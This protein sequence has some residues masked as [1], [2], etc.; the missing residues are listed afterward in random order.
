M[1]K[2]SSMLDSVAGHLE[3]NGLIKEAY[4]IDKVADQIDRSSGREQTLDDFL[5]GKVYTDEGGV[6]RNIRKAPT[7][8]PRPGQQPDDKAIDNRPKTFD[9]ETETWRPYRVNK[10][11]DRIEYID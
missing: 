2:I 9:R 5:R 6:P 1:N 8:N 4:E 10:D 7:G 3:E 11:T